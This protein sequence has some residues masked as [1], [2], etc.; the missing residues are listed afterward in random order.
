MVLMLLV[1]GS[2]MLQGL[3][4]ALRQQTANVSV[5]SRALQRAAEVHTALQW[6]KV[7]SWTAEAGAQ[8]LVHGDITRVCLRLFDDGT[9]LLVAKNETLML[10][11]RDAG[12][13]EVSVFP[14]MA[15][16]IFAR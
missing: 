13:R 8:C 7:Q 11:N 6:G 10:C 15:G 3:N 16:A 4:Q 14:R 2:L 9:L 5:E 1:T 12:R